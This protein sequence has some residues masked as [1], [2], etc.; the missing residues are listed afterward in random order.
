MRR[1]GTLGR[2]A[3][4][5][6]LLVITMSA[7]TVGATASGAVSSPASK[8]SPEVLA[9]AGCALGNGVQHVV[10]I[11]FDNVHY[12]RDNPN[13]PSDMEQL[14]ALLNFIEDY[15]TLNSNEHT[16]LIAHTADDSLTN[17]TG[18]YGDR[19]GMGIANDYE[20]YNPGN[21]SVDSAG[22]FAYWTDPVNDETSPPTAGHDTSPSMIYSATS[23]SHALPDP[24]GQNGQTETPAPW[25]PFTRAGCNVGD[26]ASANM[27]L[28][29][30][31]PDIAE[32]FGVNSP[33]QTQY[34][35]DI[36][37]LTTSPP[38]TPNHKPD[39]FADQETND[40][41][42]LSVHCAQ[43]Q[44]AA[45]CAN[46]EADRG[47]QTTPS[48]TAVPDLLPTEPGGYNG[49]TALYGNKY[50]QPVAGGAD[51]NDGS[52]TTRTLSRASGLSFLPTPSSGQ[53]SFPVLD[54]AGNLTDLFGNEMDGQYVHSAGF[55]GYGP[56]TAA[57]SLAYTAD[58]QEAG[59]PVTYTYISDLHEK[60][61]Y[62]SGYQSLGGTATAPSCTTAGASSTEAG[63]APGD[64]CYEFNA[65]QYNDAFKVFFQRL[66]DDGIT[67]A[68]TLFVFAADEGD[69]FN[70]ANVGRAIA[71]TSGNATGTTPSCTGTPGVAVDTAT[72]GQTPYQCTYPKGSI[73]EV[74]TDIHGLL[75][76][77]QGDTGSSFYSEPQ[78][79][80]VYVTGSSTNTR[81]LEHEFAGAT[82]DN[83]FTGNVNTPITNY[84]ADSQEE[85]ILHISTADPER[86]PTFIDFPES[87]IYFSS[88]T[89]DSCSTGVTAANANSYCTYLDS[90][91]LWNHGYYAPEI[92]TTWAGF[93]GPGV[94]HNGLDGFLP[95]DGPSSAGA[96]SGL[97]KPVPENL[98]GT[99][100][101]QSDMRPTLMYLTGLKDDYVEDGRVITE[102]L[103]PAS[104]NKALQ[105][106]NVAALGECYKQLNSSVGTFGSDTLAADTAA[107]ESSS[108]G[109]AAYQTF[110][111]KLAAL[112]AGR[113]SLAAILKTELWGAEFLNIPVPA[114]SLQ[115]Y[116][117]NQVVQGAANLAAG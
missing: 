32:L 48:H 114:T 21:T 35:C 116:V 36:G 37:T 3:G 102:D 50:I 100:I 1:V 17:Y 42:G 106:P 73:G 69:H 46:A 57:Q 52:A 39:S 16:P 93:V 105:A 30:P 8:Q 98:P 43:G 54:A 9:T 85:S 47:N 86:T 4:A 76:A 28:E 65:Q 89:S 74:D 13:V 31:S 49:Y 40:Y 72:S 7:A 60:K 56:I 71:P 22:S 82:I 103:A 14:P 53:D 66:A 94:A 10:D 12:N 41:V 87:D 6:G 99:W 20:T 112:A 88:G 79:E 113:N 27:D 108:P 91:Y 24:N 83:P 96:T 55:P 111:A 81:Q 107:I 77:Q 115:L 68:N 67:P 97:A 84:L 38:C 92:N 19:Q 5:A 15:G 109:D 101:D 25:V 62:P 58:L 45:V 33:E 26:V 59:V 18:L 34:L 117:C 78:G 95:Q 80:A 104:T 64:P 61:F 44:E 90:Y 75:T 2:V 51:V 23:P 29:S 70:G 110:D 11:F 63:L